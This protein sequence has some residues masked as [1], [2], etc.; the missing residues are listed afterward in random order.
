MNKEKT[1]AKGSDSLRCY[2]G[3][4]EGFSCLNRRAIYPNIAAKEV[5]PWDYASRG[6]AEFWPADD[7]LGIELLFQN[8][9]HATASELQVVA[10]P[11]SKVVGDPLENHLRNLFCVFN[12]IE[13]LCS[14]KAQIVEDL[15]LHLLPGTDSCGLRST[16]AF[17]LFD[18][19]YPDE[20]VLW[21]ESECI[22]LIF[23]HNGFLKSPVVPLR[24]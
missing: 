7:A 19:H 2:L 5:I 1:E 6:Q 24:R 13:I 21:E 14:L 15:P 3:T 16:A 20:Y 22:G 4:N 8:Q 10:C 11:F 23:D 12:R 17:G 9:T 18:L